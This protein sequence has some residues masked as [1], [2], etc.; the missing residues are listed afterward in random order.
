MYGLLSRS[1]APYL[2]LGEHDAVRVDHRLLLLLLDRGGRMR[3]RFRARRILHLFRLRDV[4]QGFRLLS[5]AT[6]FGRLLPAPLGPVGSWL[7]GNFDDTVRDATGC[8][9]SISI[10]R[11][12]SLKVQSEH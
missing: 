7:E 3:L 11:L 12:S 10:I 6:G 5:S 1:L 9:S 8:V 4:R 2:E